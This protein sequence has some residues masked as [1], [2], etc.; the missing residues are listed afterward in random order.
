M[1]TDV[2]NPNVFEL[3]SF[4]VPPN[5]PARLAELRRFAV[6]D[7]P[8]EKAF[9][10]LTALAAQVFSVPISTVTL[11]DEDRQWFKSCFGLETREVGRNVAFC[12]YAILSDEVLVVPDAKE[13]PRFA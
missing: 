7:T 3:M 9:D 1:L 8:P 5:E 6:R 12:A 10:N 13:D 4:P 11:V 2:R